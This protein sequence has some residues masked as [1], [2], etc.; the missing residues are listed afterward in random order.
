MSFTFNEKFRIKRF[1]AHYSEL[2]PAEMDT[3]CK[4]FLKKS[5]ESI[6]LKKPVLIVNPNDFMRQSFIFMFMRLGFVDY[7]FLSAYTLLDIYLGNNEDLKSVLDVNSDVVCLYLGYGEF[8][9]KRQIDVI[10]QLVN[11]LTIQGKTVWVYCR[12][13]NQG[14]EA[15]FPGLIKFFTDMKYTVVSQ[16]SSSRGPVGSSDDL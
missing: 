16:I 12:A 6:D 10:I 11:N 7:K 5:L 13:T 1:R 4:T 2:F 15:K 3:R 9:N 8:E 14:A